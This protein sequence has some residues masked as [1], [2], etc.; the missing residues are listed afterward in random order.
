MLT[1]EEFMKTAQYTYRLWEVAGVERGEVADCGFVFQD[2]GFIELTENG[3]KCVIETNEFNS[4]DIKAAAQFLYNKHYVFEYC[5]PEGVQFETMANAFP[6][7]DQSTLPAIPAD[8]K[9]SSY[10][11]DMAPSFMALDAIE[12]EGHG[13]GFIQ[14]FVD[15]VEP[16]KREFEHADGKRFCVLCSTETTAESIETNDWQTVLDYVADCRKLFA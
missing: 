12:I 5:P 4:A 10:G 8:W 6:D 11:N 15:Y 7:F 1:F 13:H 9:D 16:E 14:V 3:Y 2:G